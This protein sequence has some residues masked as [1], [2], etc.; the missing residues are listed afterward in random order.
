MPKKGLKRK[1]RRRPQ[2][3]YISAAA[4]QKLRTLASQIGEIIPATSFR[5]GGFCFQTIARKID[6]Q[7]YWT[8]GTKK[9]AIFGFLK[10]VYRDHGK[11][12]YKLFRENIAQG[13]ERRHKMGNP[14]LA[15]EIFAMDRTL[16]GLDIDLSKEFK[17][18]DLPKERPKIVPPPAAFQR[19][20]DELGLHPYL[21]PECPKLFKDGH[22]NESVRKS[23]E[24]YEHYV[25]KKSG[26]SKIGSNLMAT[27]FND[28]SPV[29]AVADVTTIRGKGLQDG[30]KF[31]SMGAMEFWRNFC[32][33][34]NEEQMA[35]QDAVAILAAVSHFL[36]YVDR[37]PE[38]TSASSPQATV[39]PTH[40][41]Q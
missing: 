30:F 22:I 39:S 40:P 11:L 34:G 38:A 21:H 7:R 15:N 25:Q 29:I 36:H 27:V 23:L 6:L 12:F 9:E 37:V 17:A 14:V 26:Q 2:R 4:I 3:R 20:V 24:K 16:R 19:I 31:L 10:A 33:H 13:I 8:S 28:T 41:L 18:L 35:H 5:K 32:T 1:Q